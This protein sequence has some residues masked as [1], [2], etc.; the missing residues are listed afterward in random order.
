MAWHGPADGESFTHPAVFYRS[1]EEYLAT[2]VPFV[3]AGQAVGEPVAVAVPGANLVAVRE[4]VAGRGGRVEDV[5]WLDMTEAGRN[6]G[7]I[8]PA[9]LRAFADEH[10][11]RRVRVIGE[12]V[13]AGRTDAEYPA[14]VQHEALINAA[15]EGRR[16]TIVCPYD[17]RRLG[18][19]A[20]ADAAAT[21]PILVDDGRSRTSQDY[22]PD[23]IV[24]AYNQPLAAPDDAAEFLITASGLGE[25]RRWATS[26]AATHGV[27]DDRWADVALVVTEL[28][29]NSLEH[30][31]GDARLRVWH[32][33]TDLVFQTANMGRMS[34][35]LVGRRPVPANA[36]RG[37]GLLTVNLMSD[38]VRV[39]TARDRTTVRACFRLAA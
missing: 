37:R 1:T 3:L 23:R 21:H 24:S 33:G 12:P 32:T 7:R 31:T 19:V 16:A 5:R 34:D 2:M 9:V 17:A 4:E 22:D 10:A 18:A 29:T 20:L 6:P 8:I 36:L 28:A 11:D 30:G 27:D 15:F 39:H 35:P 26:A 38:L 14:C 25:I 13:W